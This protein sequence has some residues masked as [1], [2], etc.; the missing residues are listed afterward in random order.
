MRIFARVIAVI[1]LAV[2][3]AADAEDVFD[4]SKT[5]L[6]ASIEAFDCMPGEEC[7]KDLPDVIGAP[8]FLR[9][10][11]AKKEVIGPRRTTA[12]RLMEQSEE[13]IL[14]QGS[15]LGLGWTLAL[16]KATGKFS[17]TLTNQEGA[18][19]FFGACTSAL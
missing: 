18:F 6:C 10:D 19:V 15:E 1:F 12:I 5:L 17:A 9:I 11:F 2:P 3:F 13:Q 8:Q 4:G 14:L 16:D 7:Q